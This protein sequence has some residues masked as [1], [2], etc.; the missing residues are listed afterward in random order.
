[1]LVRYND[2]ERITFADE[3]SMAV[4]VEMQQTGDPSVQLP[5]GAVPKEPTVQFQVGCSVDDIDQ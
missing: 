4:T 1:L 2:L 5:G 3:G